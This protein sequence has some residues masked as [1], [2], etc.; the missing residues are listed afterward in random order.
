MTHFW[1]PLLFHPSTSWS[2]PSLRQQRESTKT[3]LWTSRQPASAAV[4]RAMSRALRSSTATPATAPAWWE[5]WAAASFQS[6]FVSYHLTRVLSVLQE[7]V[8]TGPFVMRSTCRRC[9][10]KGTVIATPCHACRG[11]GQTKQRK[12]VTVPVPAG[13]SHFPVCATVEAL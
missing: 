11:A 13:Q 5:L 2:W 7:T 10:G 12:T 6:V 1:H 9:G 4:V 3:F 8:N